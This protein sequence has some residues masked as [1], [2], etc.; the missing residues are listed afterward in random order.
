[1]YTFAELKNNVA[2]I[3]QRSSDSSYKSE[4]GT[5]INLALQEL[6]N[7]YDFFLELKGEYDFTTVDGTSLYYMPLD[8]GKPIRVYDLTNKKKINI[9]TEEE[10]SDGNISNIANSTEG[11]VSTLY[12]TEVV[13]VHK[14]VSS[15]GEKVKVKSSSASDTSVT[16]RIKGYINSDLTIVGFENITLNGTT[17]VES[18]N[19][20]YKILGFSKDSDSVGYITLANSSSIELGVLGSIDRV[21][22]Y[23]AFKLGKIPDDSSTNIRVLYKKKFDKL[24]NDYDYPFV[25]CDDYL[26]YKAA[27]LAL[28][29]EKE[30]LDRALMMERMAKTAKYN[31][32]QQQ[33]SQLGTDYQHKAVNIFTQAHRV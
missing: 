7:S 8:F 33:T 23:K 4:I 21:A 16:V 14:Q 19:T 24:V 12:F 10:Y 13:G 18:A 29:Q 5:W 9:K 30:T 22:Q 27:S 1:M 31:I 26:I 25:E 11:D 17:F 15:S 28:Q 6:Y 20:Y 32:L 3:V 2:V